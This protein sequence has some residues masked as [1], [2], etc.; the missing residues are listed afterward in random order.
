MTNTIEARLAAIEANN[1][2]LGRELEAL[3]SHLR[4][5]ASVKPL[6]FHEE[7]PTITTRAPH[8]AMPSEAELQSL[9]GLVIRTH[10]V[11]RAPAKRHEPI[12]APFD[13]FRNAFLAIGLM[14]RAAQLDTGRALA[15][16]I[17]QAEDRLREA[18]ADKDIDAA[19]FVAAVLAHG[20]VMY[21]AID[22][23]PF[24]LAFGLMTHGGG[25][26]ARDAWRTVLTSG[27]VSAPSEHVAPAN[28]SPSSV[29]YG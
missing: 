16:W 13:R 29:L 4:L 24:G 17:D 15:S 6:A 14:G 9:Y 2:R 11:L 1:T 21:R 27:R 25:T 20:D 8:F 10:P 3:R 7:A 12:E 19:G 22:R 28:V 5:P 26:P 18:G 23:Y